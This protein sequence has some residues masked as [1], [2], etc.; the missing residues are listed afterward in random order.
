MQKIDTQMNRFIKY[1]L[2][3]FIIVAFIV[4]VNAFDDRISEKIKK[5]IELTGPEKFS[6][7]W[8]IF[9][10]QQNDMS[11]SPQL[12]KRRRDLAK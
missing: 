2:S 10:Q 9:C 11:H 3:F 8:L 5:G 7:T 12:Y 1:G 4:G 6:C